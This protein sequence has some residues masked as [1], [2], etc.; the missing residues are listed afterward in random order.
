MYGHRDGKSKPRLFPEPEKGPGWRSWVNLG[1]VVWRGEQESR[2]GASWGR[3]PAGCSE[4]GISGPSMG[5]GVR[6]RV[7]ERSEQGLGGQWRVSPP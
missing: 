4:P 6:G 5:K 7:L 2:V 1:K 3:D